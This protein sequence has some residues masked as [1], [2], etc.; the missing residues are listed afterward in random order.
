[1]KTLTLAAIR[2]SLMFTAVAA[3]SV[4]YPAS[5]QAVPTTYQYTGN[6]FTFA[7]APYT[8]SD[9]VTGMLTLAGPLASNFNGTVTPTA[10]TFSD[11]VQTLTNLNA[12]FSSFLFVTGP[13]GQ[14]TGWDI[15]VD[16]E[17]HTFI[18]T[19]NIA[20]FQTIDIGISV[21]ISQGS[22]AFNQDQPGRWE[23]RSA[24]TDSGS[25]LSMLTL[26]LMALGLVARRFQRA[27]G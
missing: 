19:T 8:T 6:P 2:C 12:V 21:G 16:R 18:S 15:E 17:L 3:L 25:T 20:D 14:I 11:G 22:F 10:F 4:A 5:V 13:T 9:F 24:V 23:N 26:T 27:A 7:I 1:M